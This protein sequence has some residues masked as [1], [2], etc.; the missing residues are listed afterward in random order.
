MI[1]SNRCL[2]V[3]FTTTLLALLA[4]WPA[5]SEGSLWPAR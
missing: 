2:G 3:F 1:E 4:P 5:E